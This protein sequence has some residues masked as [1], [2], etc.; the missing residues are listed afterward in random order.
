M[1]AN[2][3]MR[4]TSPTPNIQYVGGAISTTV[5]TDSGTTNLSLT[6]LTGGISTS[7]ETGDV[8]IA[9]FATGSAS[10]R[11]LSITDGSTEYTLIGA[12]FYSDDSY[13]TNLRVAYKKLTAADASTVFGNTMALNDAGVFC[14]SV[15]RGVSDMVLD[16]PAQQAGS[17]NSGRPEPPPITPVS[18]GA[19]ILAIGA[20]ALNTI[21]AA[22][23]T[24]ELSNFISAFSQDTND[25]VLGLGSFAWTS[26][27]FTPLQWISGPS[28]T[29]A[30]QASTTI[31][32]RP[33]T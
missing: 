5:G 19:V 24:T 25:V 4:A 18:E 32:L 20:A 8:V 29:S 15:W 6:S 27:T 33:A 30:S 21:S 1:L 22:F 9:A 12:E 7:A 13:D 23:T 31:A 14:V 11:T 28:S 10:N 3:L 26:G 2:M 17:G 16:V